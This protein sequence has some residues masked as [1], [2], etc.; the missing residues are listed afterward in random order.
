MS[1]THDGEETSASAAQPRS[2]HPLSLVFECLS[3]ARKNILPALFAGFSAASGGLIGFWIA[4][5]I[6][7]IAI[8]VSAFKY[9][10]FR[11]A[12]VG[13]ELVIDHGLIFR[14][15]RTIP[16]ARIQNIDMIQNPLH[17]M[18]GVGEVRVET[19]S[20][21]EPEAVMRVL[22]VDE[23]QRLRT[24]VFG[25]TLSQGNSASLPPAATPI[26]EES[27]FVGPLLEHPPAATR[28]IAADHAPHLPAQ[29]V[30]EIPTRL[31]LLAG[32][33]SNRGL[34]FVG[35]ILGFFWQERFAKLLGLDPARWFERVPARD[36]G[37]EFGRE[38]ARDGVA[39]RGVFQ[40]FREG[41]STLE[42]VVY[43][44]LL[45]I[46]TAIVVKVLSAVW[47]ILRFYGYRLELDGE[48]FR[49]RCGLI[50]KVTATVPRNRIQLI[51]VH[52]PLLERWLGIAHIRIETAGGGKENEDAAATVGRRWFLPLV[53]EKDIGSLLPILHPGVESN[54][55]SFA[56]QSL[57]KRAG[58]RIRRLGVY[59]A[60]AIG[61]VATIVQPYWGWS[62]GI[63]TW[64]GFWF[65]AR[66]KLKS[67]K[68]AQ[69]DWGIVF[70]S[71]MLYRK[72]TLTF[73]DKI[74]T[75]EW[76]QSP[77]DRRWRMAGLSIDTVGAGPADHRIQIDM[78]DAADATAI[79][80][81]VASRLPWG[82]ASVVRTE[83]RD[84][85]KNPNGE[86]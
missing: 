62:L 16:I 33:C 23:L 17:R 64:G 65:Y 68:F 31:L 5:V 30:Y 60:L 58:S 27:D 46:V 44:S 2:L 12:I 59:I 20:G 50:T 66:K 4:L 83:L 73:F 84:R 47:Y 57:S 32:L 72:W 19:A 45:V 18:L 70:K 86:S 1:D 78:L 35:L 71:G 15:H 6:F 61:L 69:T 54:D 52:R 56:W 51:S 42:T 43:V 22:A 36:S 11:Y 49:V 81:H 34:V 37:R 67:R 76:S 39:L 26:V 13:R 9:F 8:L 74:Q 25:G 55:T 3:L 82:S 48:D 41:H 75:V 40:W 63:L 10:T 80:E 85:N 77:F 38:I 7:A 29:L 21:K 53:R 14:Q 24:S 28:P 79:Y